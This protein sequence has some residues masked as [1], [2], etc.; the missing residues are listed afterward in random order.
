MG[1]LVGK[2]RPKS[3]IHQLTKLCRLTLG[4][5][6]EG[7]KINFMISYLIRREFLSKNQRALSNREKHQKCPKVDSG[8]TVW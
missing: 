2:A 7:A 3:A 5:I 6:N 8:C 1:P 4:A